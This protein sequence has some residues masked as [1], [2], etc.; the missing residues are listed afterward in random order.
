MTLESVQFQNVRLGAVFFDPATGQQ[1]QKVDG[2]NAY[3]EN[4]HGERTNAIGDS[5]SKNFTKRDMVEAHPN[6]IL[7]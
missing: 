5:G 4:A 7:N 6:S 2:L 3:G 1:F